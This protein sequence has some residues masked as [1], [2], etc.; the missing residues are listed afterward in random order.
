MLV[1]GDHMKSVNPEGYQ[2][3]VGQVMY[4]NKKIGIK[5]NNPTRELSR[6]MSHPGE[7]HWKSLERYGGYIKHISFDCLGYL[8]PNEL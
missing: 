8:A 1:K 7:Q 2:K 6:F 5:C 3:V 4:W